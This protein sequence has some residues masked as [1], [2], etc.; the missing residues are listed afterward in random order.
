[1]DFSAKLPTEDLYRLL[2][3]AVRD[4]AIYLL[5]I[6]G[7]I[8][9]WNTGAERFKGYSADEII[10][11]HFSVF[12]TDEDRAAGIPQ[13]ALAT[14][15]TDGRFEAEGW[16]VRKNGT[17]FWGSVVIDPVYDDQK[18]LIGFAKIT[19]DITEQK[20]HSEELQAA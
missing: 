9:S 10:G 17:R 19:R 2:I 4:Y 18:K 20:S 8:I 1:M 3:D 13:L 6:N 16:R 15:R 14:A 5:D 12:Y 11:Q 7:Q